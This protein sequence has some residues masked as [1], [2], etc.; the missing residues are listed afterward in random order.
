MVDGQNVQEYLQSHYINAFKQVALRSKGMPHVLGFDSLNEPGNGFIGLNLDGSNSDVAPSLG[1]TF[2]PIAAILTGAGFPQRVPYKE[3][4][5]LGVRETRQDEINP[6]GISCWLEN[7][8]DI[9][10][11]EGVWSHGAHDTPTFTNNDYFVK[12]KGETVNYFRDYLSPFIRRF[13]EELRRINPET[14]IF[15]EGPAEATWKGTG[16]DFVLPDCAVNAPHW[17]DVATMGLHRFMDHF[18]YDY[19]N[20]RLLFGGRAIRNAFQHQLASLK[21]LADTYSKGGPSIIGEFG[22]PYDINSKKA[23]RIFRSTPERAW[24]K[25]VKAL[26]WYYDALDA[27]LLH[28]CQWNYNPENANEW[29]DQWNLEDFSIFSRDQQTLDWRKDIDAGGRA[30]PGFCRPHFIA[31]AGKPLKM[32]FTMNRGVFIFEF[33]GDT[34][35]SSP[36]VLYVPTVHYPNGFDIMVSEGDIRREEKQLVSIRIHENGPHRVKITRK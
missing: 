27:N 4:K 33:D 12:R 18:S 9:W 7:A 24:R 11:K 19:I 34:S 28:S 26:T 32:E 15:Y 14:I 10:R 6:K 13:A 20:G 2:T 21:A 29:G 17:Y 30:I 22:L 1:Y 16:V 25:H 8:E 35:L 36:T 31:V 3:V 23:Y 5:G